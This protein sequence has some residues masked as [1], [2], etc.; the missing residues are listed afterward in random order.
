[1][2]VLKNSIILNHILVIIKPIILLHYLTELTIAL[3]RLYLAFL[4]H[5]TDVEIGVGIG[6]TGIGINIGVCGDFRDGRKHGGSLLSFNVE[7]V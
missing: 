2:R 1:M 5:I 7:W 3:T 6:D 4:I